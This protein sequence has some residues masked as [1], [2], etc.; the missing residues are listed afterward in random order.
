MLNQK[1]FQISKLKK[2][3]AVQ[4]VSNLKSL[5]IMLIKRYRN[6]KI[7]Q[8]VKIIYQQCTNYKS[9]SSNIII[10][11]GIIQQSKYI[12]GAYAYKKEIIKH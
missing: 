10:F 11:K 2:K 12:N 6:L 9:K 7:A 3:M 8:E 5:C 1:Y 4:E